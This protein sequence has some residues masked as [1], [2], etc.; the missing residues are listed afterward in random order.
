MPLTPDQIGTLTRLISPERL[1]K[2]T[3]LTGSPE[4]AIELHQETLRLGAAL[5]NVTASVEIALRNAICE[6]L[7]HHFGVANWLI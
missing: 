1:G 5:M 6:N 2:L 4:Q 7:S 3:A